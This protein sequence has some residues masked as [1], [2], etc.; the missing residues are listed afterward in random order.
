MI[1]AAVINLTFAS[2]LNIILSCQAKTTTRGR[3]A[4]EGT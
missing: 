1:F 2:G 3:K 4:K